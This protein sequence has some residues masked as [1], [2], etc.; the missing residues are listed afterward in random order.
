[1]PEI[2]K[3][4][5]VWQKEYWDRFIRGQNHFNKAVESI[6]Q[7]PVKAG[8]VSSAEDWPWSSVKCFDA[9]GPPALPDLRKEDES[10]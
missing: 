1:M 9:G 6:H 7:N 4:S 5:I 10:Q 2:F 8:L 3:G